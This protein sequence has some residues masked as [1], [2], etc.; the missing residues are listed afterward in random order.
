MAVINGS[1][2]GPVVSSTLV[3]LDYPT[4]RPAGRPVASGPTER[5]P[6]QVNALEPV[7]VSGA[8]RSRRSSIDTS[9]TGSRGTSSM[10]R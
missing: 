5:H 3:P 4:L 9:L 6:E 10:A 2:E 1:N 8:V 7:R